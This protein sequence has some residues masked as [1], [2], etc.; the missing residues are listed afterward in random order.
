M[1]KLLLGLIPLALLISCDKSEVYTPVNQNQ[2]VTIGYRLI[3]SNSMTRAIAGEEVIYDIQQTLPTQVDL[4]LKN[5]TEQFVVRTN[6]E[7]SISVG[8]YTYSGVAY[9]G[10]LG[11]QINNG[12][13][14]TASPYITF[15]GNLEI[16]KGTSQ[17]YVNGTYKSFAIIVDY[18]EILTA[19]YKTY[20]GE[21]K[22]IPFTRFDNVG[23]IFAQDL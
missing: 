10:Q 23:V 7:A 12:A 1:K 19:E 21:W 14:L 18:D 16:V 8:A 22:P 11:D 9:A 13:Y 5:G 2:K 6:Q 4:I 20:S 17:Y 3:E 15:A